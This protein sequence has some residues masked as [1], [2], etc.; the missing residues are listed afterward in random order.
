[1]ARA[2]APKVGKFTGGGENSGGAPINHLCLSMSAA[3][4]DALSSRLAAHGVTLTTGGDQAFGAQGP[5]QR[6][7]YFCDPDGNVIEMRHY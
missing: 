3:E 1:M 7:A 6:S 2:N 5:A 4:Y